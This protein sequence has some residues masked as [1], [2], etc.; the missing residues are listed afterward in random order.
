MSEFIHTSGLSSEKLTEF[1]RRFVNGENGKKL[2]EEFDSYI[3]YAS[4]EDTMIVLDNLLNQGFDFEIVKNNVAKIINV[5]SNSLLSQQQVLPLKDHFLYYM[6]LENREM[7]KR[8]A[9]IRSV[10]RSV[11]KDNNEDLSKSLNSLLSFIVEIKQYD[12]HYLKKENILFPYLEKTFTHYRCLHLMWSFHDDYR[13]SLK[14]LEKILK[15]DKPDIQVINKEL[16]KLFFVI[17]PIIFREEKIIFPVAIKAVH[18]GIWDEMMIQSEEIGWCFDIKPDFDKVSG[19]K[20][21]QSNLIDLGTGYLKADQIICMLESL[22]VDITFVDEND[23]VKYFSGIKHRIFP[24][25]KAIIGRKVQNCHPKE[26]VHIVEKI[27]EEFKKGEQK[28]AEFWI[29]MR[30]RFIHIRYFAMFDDLN[31]YRG[32]IEVSQDVTDIRNLDGEQRLLNWEK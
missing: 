15:T 17:F 16:G 19:N 5:F 6:M 32:T 27:I 28:Q 18:E 4:A 12:L 14:A 21:L 13:N 9:G 23:E 24:R 20:A 3:K 26:S 2:I 29:Q 1:A 30:G 11:F 22:P 8:V 31:N 10:I 7:E 25:T